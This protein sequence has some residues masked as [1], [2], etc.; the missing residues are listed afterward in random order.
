MKYTFTFLF[1][2]LI[3]G[4]SPYGYRVRIEPIEPYPAP[5]PYSGP[6][7]PPEEVEVIGTGPSTQIKVTPSPS[8]KPL[9]PLKSE[10]PQV[11]LPESPP[12][13]LRWDFTLFPK[14]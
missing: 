8:T 10:K 11:V 6:Y 12:E 4:C 14:R 5:P 2:C 1:F 7:V 3:C 9:P 13:K